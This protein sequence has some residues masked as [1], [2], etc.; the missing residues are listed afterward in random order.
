VNGAPPIDEHI[1][2]DDRNER[3]AAGLATLVN[4]LQAARQPH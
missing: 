2:V 3:F 1:W 4:G